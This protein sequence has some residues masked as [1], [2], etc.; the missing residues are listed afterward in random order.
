MNPS[1]IQFG[2]DISSEV[3]DQVRSLILALVNSAIS[4]EEFHS[5][6]QVGFYVTLSPHLEAFYSKFIIATQHGCFHYYTT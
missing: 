6:L 2:D 3:G 4:T 1:M 5:K